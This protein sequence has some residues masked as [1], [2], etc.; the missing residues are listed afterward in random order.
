MRSIEQRRADLRKRFSTWTP[1]T[2]DG[3]L[4]RCAELYGDRPLVL[5]DDVT[6]TYREVADQSRA[7]ADALR[8]MGVG[9]GDRVGMLVANYPEFVPFKFAI[10][11]TGATAIPFN[12][13]Y[14][15]EE[16]GYVLEQSRCKVLQ[17]KLNG[18]A[19]R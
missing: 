8:A 1:A 16:L 13:L 9:R 15:T 5:T 19:V 12:F 7:I 6:L 3:W 14:R 18:I 10:A 2:L 17:R 4:D 11:R